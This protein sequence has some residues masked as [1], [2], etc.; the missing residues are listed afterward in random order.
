MRPPEG[1]CDAEDARGIECREAAGTGSDRSATRTEGTTGRDHRYRTDVPGAR[2]TSTPPSAPSL[3][4][5]SHTTHKDH[6]R[7]GK[8]NGLRTHEA[9]LGRA[10]QGKGEDQVSGRDDR[11]CPSGIP[12]QATGSWTSSLQW[13]T[14]RTRFKSAGATGCLSTTVSGV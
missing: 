14:Q 13:E 12:C 8:A 11:T 5:T 3:A 10:P 7:G 1:D 9:L 6:V 4:Q 2:A